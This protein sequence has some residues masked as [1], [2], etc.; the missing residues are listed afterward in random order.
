MAA[1]SSIV[2]TKSRDLIELQGPDAFTK[3]RK[4]AKKY[5]DLVKRWVKE[6]EDLAEQKIDKRR[7]L[8]LLQ[9]KRLGGLFTS[10]IEIQA[11]ANESSRISEQ[12][13]VKRLYIE[14]RYARDTCSSLPKTSDIFRL[15]RSYKNLESSEY[16]KNLMIYM[17]RIKSNSSA[18]MEDFREAL[19]NLLQ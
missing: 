14:V 2:K 13:K 9:L 17:D 16:A 8:D 15:K 4:T 7:N 11:F 3:E 19:S 1:S 10:S 12:D 18:T 6:Q 5:N